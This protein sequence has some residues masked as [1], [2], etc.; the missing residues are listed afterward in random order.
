MRKKKKAPIHFQ[1]AFLDKQEKKHNTKTVDGPATINLM[2]TN[3]TL[4][5]LHILIPRVGF[6]V[7]DILRIHTDL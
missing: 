2:I 6:F 3:L 1:I 4:I 5:R 7:E